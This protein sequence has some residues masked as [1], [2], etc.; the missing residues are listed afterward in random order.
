MAVE[1]LTEIEIAAP[2]QKVAGYASDPTNAPAWY[3]DIKSVGWKTPPPM[4]LGSRMAFL[5]EFLGRRLAYTHEVSEFVPGERLVMKTAEGPFPMETSHVW[6]DAGPGRC[7]TS[8]QNR[9]RPSGFSRVFAPM[10]AASMRKANRKDLAKL[11]RILEAGTTN[12]ACS[13]LDHQDSFPIG[14]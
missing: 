2:R 5:A 8:L 6:S 7:R 14:L 9:G 11:K 12:P 1:V 3:V 4:D 13:P 10:M